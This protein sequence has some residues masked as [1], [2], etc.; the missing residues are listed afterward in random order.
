MFTDIEITANDFTIFELREG[1][2][3]LATHIKNILDSKLFEDHNE[4]IDSVISPDDEHSLMSYLIYYQMFEDCA[5]LK[6]L[7][8][9]MIIKPKKRTK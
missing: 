6:R 2:L 1:K 3:T 7:Y 4:A 8:D 9:E 5:L